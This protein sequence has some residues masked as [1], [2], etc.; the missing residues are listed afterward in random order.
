[1]EKEQ[2]GLNRPQ[3]Q[4]KIVTATQLYMLYVYS[5]VHYEYYSMQVLLGTPCQ[6]TE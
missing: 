1:M 2:S 6:K 4:V 3:R 5:P